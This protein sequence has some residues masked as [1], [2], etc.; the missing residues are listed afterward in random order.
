MPFLVVISNFFLLSNGNNKKKCERN[1]FAVL[2]SFSAFFFRKETKKKAFPKAFPTAIVTQPTSSNNNIIARFFCVFVQT[3]T[4]FSLIIFVFVLNPLSLHVLFFASLSTTTTTTTLSSTL[5]VCEQPTIYRFLLLLFYF[6]F[7][8]YIFPTFYS[9]Y[10]V[11][12]ITHMYNMHTV[13][14]AMII[15]SVRFL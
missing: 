14:L 9:R 6:A 11:P 1:Y 12:C 7:I 8:K 2:V 13:V 10:S 5:R 4:L 3:E 15:I